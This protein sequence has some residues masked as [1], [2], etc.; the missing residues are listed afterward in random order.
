M[1]DD[2]WQPRTRDVQRRF[3]RVAADFDRAD[4]VHRSTAAGLLERLAPVTLQ[5]GHVL[6]LGAGTGSLGRELSRFFGR[7]RVVS[8]DL[9]HGMLRRARH[10]RWRFARRAELQASA[11]AIPLRTDSIDAVVANQLLPWLGDPA[12]LFAEVARVL[13]R[14]GLFA[15]AALGPDSLRE[16]RDAFADD[17]P[18]VFRF[19]DMHDLGDAMVRAGLRDP[20]LDVDHLRIEYRDT[21]SLY[22]D[23][24]ACGARN[25]LA[26]RRRTLTG[27]ARFAR[28]DAA[29]AAQFREGRLGV[30]LELVYGHAWG[31]AQPM[32][33]GEFRVDVA[34]LVG[35]RRQHR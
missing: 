26:G 22:R 5:A 13:R 32:Q 27:K 7:A 30:T 28:L 15:F 11:S 34:E 33:D 8:L 2:A 31:G 10:K 19:P 25:T 17:E 3:D 35:R 23:L 6:D 1:N 24:A 20:V 16:L 14:D 4:F 21:R 29:L 18:H 9:S 12:A